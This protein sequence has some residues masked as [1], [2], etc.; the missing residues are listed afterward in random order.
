VIRILVCAGREYSDW[1]LFKRTLDDLRS[2]YDGVFLSHA[3]DQ[4]S[5]LSTFVKRWATETKSVYDE[6][7]LFERAPDLV[8]A[9][10]G[11]TTAALRQAWKKRI[12][13]L[14]INADGTFVRVGAGW[15][16]LLNRRR[17]VVS[18]R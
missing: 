15:K 16:R 2:A 10:P 12:P 13:G 18:I 11:E 6:I 17:K 1:L 7:V 3:G 5:T 8:L 9:F 14:R 4:H